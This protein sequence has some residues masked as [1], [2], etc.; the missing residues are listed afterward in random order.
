VDAIAG[1]QMSISE[2]LFNCGLCD[3]ELGEICKSF[4]F[5]KTSPLH[6]QTFFTVWI[7][8]GKKLQDLSV[9]VDSGALISFI[10]DH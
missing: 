9:L 1:E 3:L 8:S 10:S 2:L 7:M 5:V 6:N 4:H